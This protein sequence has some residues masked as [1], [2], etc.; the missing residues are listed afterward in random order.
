MPHFSEQKKTS[1]ASYLPTKAK[2]HFNSKWALR[3]RLEKC[4]SPNENHPPSSNF[5]WTAV[6]S[7][8]FIRNI[9]NKGQ[10]E[11]KKQ[12][13]TRQ[14]LLSSP[15]CYPIWKHQKGGVKQKTAPR[16]SKMDAFVFF[17]ESERNFFKCLLKY[18]PKQPFS[19]NNSCKSKCSIHK[20]DTVDFP[21]QN[22]PDDGT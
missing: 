14:P 20:R 5:V 17:Q 11:K 4:P 1:T 9:F 12:Q 2:T 22:L 3:C 7:L 18:S 8:L 21:I 6:E 15:S 16:S 13:R 10:K 19:S